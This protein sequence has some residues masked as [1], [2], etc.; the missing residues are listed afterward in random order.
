MTCQKNIRGLFGFVLF[1]H[2]PFAYG[3]IIQ[4]CLMV[5]HFKIS[6]MIFLLDGDHVTAGISKISYRSYLLGYGGKKVGSWACLALLHSVTLCK[7][8]GFSDFTVLT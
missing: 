1:C 7:S 5:Y 6:H 4:W 3:R 8:L 2:V